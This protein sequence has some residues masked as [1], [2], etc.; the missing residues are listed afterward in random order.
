[1]VR[2]QRGGTT[3]ATALPTL[4]GPA[5]GVTKQTVPPI[6]VL[7]AGRTATRSSSR[8]P[9]AAGTCQSSDQLAVTLPNGVSL[10]PLPARVSACGLLVH[11]LVEQCPAARTDPRQLAGQRR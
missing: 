8:A 4:S 7:P 9:S 11:P 6:L 2:A 10:G 5:G 3:L 1:M